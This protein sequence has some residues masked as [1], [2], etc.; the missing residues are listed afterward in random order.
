MLVFFFLGA[1]DLYDILI[2]VCFLHPD[3]CGLVYLLPLVQEVD[4]LFLL[5]P[6]VLLLLLRL[7]AD[8]LS[9]R[10]GEVFALHLLLD[11][12]ILSPQRR[13]TELA[14]EEARLLPLVGGADRCDHEKG[15]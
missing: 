14:A 1:L 3:N 2:E 4:F 15:G 7:L 9:K 11:C 12:S 8:Y 6:V 5:L 10:E 13:L